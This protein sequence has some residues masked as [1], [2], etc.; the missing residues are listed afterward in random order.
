M[1]SMLAVLR[2]S[3]PQLPIHSQFQVSPGLAQIDIFCNWQVF[4]KGS[5][6]T[7]GPGQAY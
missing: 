2:R 3:S 1:W 5:N 6:Y 4:T 7:A